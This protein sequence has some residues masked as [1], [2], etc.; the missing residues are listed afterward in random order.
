MNVS[1][2]LTVRAS[3]ILAI[4]IYLIPYF[5]YGIY[6]DEVAVQLWSTRFLEDFPYRS[7]VHPQCIDTFLARIPYVLYPSAFS[8]SIFSFI[9]DTRIHRG[10]MAL[11][12]MGLIYLMYR[13][14]KS[15]SKNGLFFFIVYIFLILSGTKL[16]S[17]VILRPEIFV[18]I[19][20]LY[21]YYVVSKDINIFNELFILLIYLICIYIHPFSIYF[22]PA[23][24]VVV[25]RNISIIIISLVATFYSY[26]LWDLQLFNCD[27]INVIKFNTNFNINPVEI[28]RSPINH[29]DEILNNI[30]INRI[31]E[32]LNRITIN[33]I[34]SNS[35]NY[36]PGFESSH[37]FNL[38]NGI[39]VCAF[40]ISLIYSLGY[41]IYNIIFFKKINK[42]SLYLTLIFLGVITHL[43]LNK[44][45][46][47]YA[48]NF[49]YIVLTFLTF[50]EVSR[51]V[52]NIHYYKTNI[53]I[54]VLFGLI[55]NLQIFRYTW[56]HLGPNLNLFKNTYYSA[57]YRLM[58]LNKFSECCSNLSKDSF[59]VDDASYF[60]LKNKI[61]YPVPITYA[62]IFN[63]SELV[64]Q[65][66]HVKYI[67]ARCDALKQYKNNVEIVD[68]GYGDLNICLKKY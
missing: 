67:I 26:R 13:I 5:T 56:D 14:F 41:I 59:V 22:L 54:I 35:S 43:I 4:F 8:L 47:F 6:P 27:D 60:I 11:I 18:S 45:N 53:I 39:S 16:F 50:V 29:L 65:K 23:V 3:L 28:L 34:Y 57:S 40:L 15:K 64:Y 66:R 32:V 42:N 38:S 30:D 12:L 33:K 24:L 17:L 58:V 21:G 20:I 68:G 55:V 37:L 61:K 48:V 1:N 9:H 2:L 25:R 63:T 19:L 36:L 52:K 46:S 51:N 7:G 49:W 62:N 44:T 10:V 31:K